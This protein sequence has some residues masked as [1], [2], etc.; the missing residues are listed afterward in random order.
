[1]LEVDRSRTTFA[2]MQLDTVPRLFLL[3]PRADEDPKLRMQDFEMNPVAKLPLL[4]AEISTK[5]NMQVGSGHIC[6]NMMF[7]VFYW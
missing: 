5:S 4:L 7:S 6:S 3:P 1:M 2:T